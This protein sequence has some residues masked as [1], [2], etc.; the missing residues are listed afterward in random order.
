[1]TKILNT[2]EKQAHAFEN[3]KGVMGYKNAMQVPKFT[4]VV[5]NVG[6]GSLKDKKKIEVIENRLNKISGQKPALRGSKKSIASFKVREGDPVGLVVTLRGARMFAF[7]D[8]LIF[9]AFPRTKDFRGLSKKGIDEMGNYSIGVKEN[10]IFPET[11]DEDL[12]DVFG[13]TITIGTTASN[14]K[15]AL[16]FLSY[17]GFPFKKEEIEEKTAIK[18]RS[19][20]KK[21]A[22][23]V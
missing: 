1:M 2:K 10:T 8:K 11:S 4:K 16:A 9:V 22:V 3:L 7:I 20:K 5:I 14:K 19:R 6:I 12:K 17:I 13:M 15:E 23:T 18:T 21:E